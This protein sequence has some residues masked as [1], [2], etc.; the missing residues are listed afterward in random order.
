[1]RLA[2]IHLLCLTFL[3]LTTP[4]TWASTPPEGRWEPIAEIWD[5]F[6][7]PRLDTAKWDDRN[8]YNKGKKPGLFVPRNI[9]LDNGKLNIWAR[10]ENVPGA[11]SGY[12]SFTTAAITSSSLVKYGY[13]EVRAKVMRSRVTNAFWLY[14]WTETGTYEIDIFEIAGSA[15]GHERTIHTNTHVYYGAPE[16]E[17]DQNRI[18]DP[19]KWQAPAPLADEYHIYGLEWNDK[20]LKWYFDDKLISTKANEHWHI[21]MSIKFSAE[22]WPGWVGLPSKGELPA[23]FQ[24]NYFR[25]WKKTPEPVSSR[26]R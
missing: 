24:V 17:N 7:A 14:R 19:S 22:T 16:L 4:W 6:D 11:P 5:E 21:P 12:H 9:Q 10:S 1:M 13:F 25:A 23:V 20:E 8:L 3:M 2:F 15:P 26:R 18:S